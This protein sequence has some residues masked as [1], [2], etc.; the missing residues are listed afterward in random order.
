MRYAICYVSTVAKEVNEEEIDTL[1]EN[2]ANNNNNHDV[3]GILLY[4]EGN[5]LQVME[6]DKKYVLD[7]YGKIE[8]D[9]RHHNIIQVL[10]KEIEQGAYDGYKSERITHNKKYNKNLLHDYLDQVKGMN[11]SI[12]QT[13]R[14]ILSVFIE[15]R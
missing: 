8:R 13:V 4:S 14:N 1:L 7:L 6:G 9:P 5:F 10:G 2:S 11:P 3:R 12:Q 15:T